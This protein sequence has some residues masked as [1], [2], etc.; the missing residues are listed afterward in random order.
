MLDFLGIAVQDLMIYNA[1]NQ[2]FAKHNM[3]QLQRNSVCVV[4]HNVSSSI[5]EWAHRKTFQCAHISSIMQQLFRHICHASLAMGTLLV[6]AGA[7]VITPQRR[8]T[9]APQG[10]PQVYGGP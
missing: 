1:V 9:R 2:A 3:N 4:F 8:F 5:N 7:A 10:S 6:S